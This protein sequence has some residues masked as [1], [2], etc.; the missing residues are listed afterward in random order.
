MPQIKV[1][2]SDPNSPQTYGTTVVNNRETFRERLMRRFAAH[3]YVRVINIDDE[4]LIWQYMPEHGEHVEFTPDPMK[5]TYRDDPELWQL[6]PGQDE[7]LVGA[8]AYLMID[9]LYKKVIS[10][11]TIARNPNLPLGQ[12][13][14]FNWTDGIAQEDLIDRIY[15]GKE[16]PEFTFKRDEATIPAAPV[17]AD[18]I[19]HDLGLDEPTQSET[20]PSSKRKT[21]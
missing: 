16:N 19:A 3:E 6:D 12:A 15:L 2:S 11:K 20:S 10:K 18:Q 1:N 9:A 14:N 17:L 13:R 21:L 4:P 8:N 7:V 5:I